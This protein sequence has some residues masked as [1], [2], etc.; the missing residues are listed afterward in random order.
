MDVRVIHHIPELRRELKAQRCRG[1][2]IGV[3]PTMGALHEGHGRLIERAAA[4]CDFVVVT[5]F[6]NPIQFNDPA[7][8]AKYPR[9]LE[10]D[11]AF[12]AARGA[13]LVFA[14]ANEEI[15]PHEPRTFVEVLG[16]T[17]FMEGHFRPGHFRGVATVVAKLFNIVQPDKAYFGEKDAQQLAAIRRMTA[18]LNFPIEVVE[19]PTVRESDGLALSSRN[20]RLGPEER[21]VAIA[22]YEALCAA[23]ER[24]LPPFL[25]DTRRSPPSTSKSPILT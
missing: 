2:V 11:M 8:F 22:L 6:V 14:P 13:N 7:D 10:L 18:E 17:D 16:V 15:Y 1:R 19:V 25:R 12:S 20:A 23:A 3:V 5:V 21:R 24:P 9:T 4:D